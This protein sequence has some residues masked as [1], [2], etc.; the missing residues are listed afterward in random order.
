LTKRR[1][2]SATTVLVLCAASVVRFSAALSSPRA[3]HTRSSA[4][5]RAF[6]GAVGTRSPPRPP[7]RAPARTIHHRG[8]RRE[9]PT[10]ACWRTCATGE[11]ARAHVPILLGSSHAMVSGKTI[12]LRLTRRALHPGES[13][14]PWTIARFPFD[15]IGDLDPSYCA[16]PSRHTSGVPAT[17]VGSTSLSSWLRTF[18]DIFMRQG[19]TRS[20]NRLAHRR[21]EPAPELAARKCSS[22]AHDGV[23]SG[24]RRSETTESLA[25]TRV[26]R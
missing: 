26:S 1:S 6:H 16:R 2:P 3:G 10:R 21:T 9:F 23:L 20:R 22:R 4:G 19:T 7:R 8:R 25:L 18:S 15:V 12:G 17:N 14:E 24:G 11:G 13:D 5:T